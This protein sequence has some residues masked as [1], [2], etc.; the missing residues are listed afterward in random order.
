MSK[1]VQVVKFYDPTPLTDEDDPHEVDT[2]V[3]I[4]FTQRFTDRVY[5]ELADGYMSLT[6]EEFQQMR[7][8][9]NRAHRKRSA[10]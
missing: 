9:L 8:A 3:V 5:E 2:P 1:A 6:E 10:T 7:K 4:E